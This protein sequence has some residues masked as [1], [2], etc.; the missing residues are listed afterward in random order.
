MREREREELTGDLEVLPQSDLS[1]CPAN[2]KFSTILFLF[3]FHRLSLSPQL[4]GDALSIQLILHCF[5]QSRQKTHHWTN[6]ATS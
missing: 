5:L 1:S 6:T 3:L 2:T 4:L